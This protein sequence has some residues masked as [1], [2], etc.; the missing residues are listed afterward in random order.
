MVTDVGS[1]RVSRADSQVNLDMIAAI[2]IFKI[3]KDEAFKINLANR[4]PVIS[5]RFLACTVD[6]KEVANSSR[7]K[8]PGDITVTELRK[9]D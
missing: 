6:F 8:L 9:Q 1:D 3:I 4:S 7:N 5:Q 2:N